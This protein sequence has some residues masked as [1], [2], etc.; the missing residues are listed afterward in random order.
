MEKRIGFGPRL[1]AFVIDMV[2]VWILA[3]ILS[4]VSSSWMAVQAQQQIDG[5]ISSNPIFAQV[6]TP[7]MVNMLVTTTRISLIVIFA[8]VQSFWFAFWLRHLHRLLLCR[9][10]PP[11]GSARY[12]VPHSCGEKRNN[13]K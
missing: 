3:A 1:G 11:S 8:V 4:R 7:E 13:R 2:F 5:I 10:R 6:Y 9:W 12:D